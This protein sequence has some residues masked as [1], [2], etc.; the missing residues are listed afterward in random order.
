MQGISRESNYLGEFLTE[1]VESFCEE[2]L[3]RIFG[4][5]VTRLG[6]NIASMTFND[7]YQPAINV[8]LQGKTKDRG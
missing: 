1:L 5:T 3:V 2:E 8:Q 6:R 7:D 4:S